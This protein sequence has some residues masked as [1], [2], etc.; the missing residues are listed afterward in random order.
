ME[1]TPPG[2]ASDAAPAPVTTPAPATPAPAPVSPPAAP[3]S[4]ASP[5]SVSDIDALLA[6]NFAANPNETVPLPPESNTPA[7]STPPPVPVPA[8]TPVTAPT[9]AAADPAEPAPTAEATALAEAAAAAS[10]KILPHRISTSQ[11]DDES[12][13]AMV[14]HR[15]LNEGKKPGDPGFVSLKKCLAMI[16][17]SMAAPVAAPLEPSM[18]PAQPFIEQVSTLEKRIAE[19]EEK[20]K[21]YSE[22]PSLY[23]DELSIERVGLEFAKRDVERAKSDAEAARVQEHNQF[24]EAQNV[25]RQR[26]IVAAVEKYPM[27][28][29]YNSALRAKA[30]EIATALNDPKH[31]EHALVSLPSAPE[32]IADRAAQ[33]MAKEM[34][35]TGKVSFPQAMAHLLA[36]AT[37][38]ALVQQQEQRKVLPAAGSNLGT[39]VVQAPTVDQKVAA[40]GDDWKAAEALLNSGRE[41][42]Y[43]V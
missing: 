40:I 8:G 33:E 42:V 37:A 27:L 36:T 30:N 4:P 13:R 15:D 3:V 25:D 23:A 26:S 32:L 1:I 29:D 21:E 28:A 12:Q 43:H 38:P 5:E 18:D 39:S 11:F 22:N 31:R 41:P 16:E 14:L 35:A 2:Q 24:V 7:G 9:T 10:E 6:K 19:H 34:A 17:E 20:I